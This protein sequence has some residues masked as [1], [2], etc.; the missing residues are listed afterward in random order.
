MS[1][2]TNT[3][4]P[5]APKGGHIHV[6][7]VPVNPMRPWGDAVDAIGSYA[8]GEESIHQIG[9]KYPPQP[10]EL[11]E[12]E[13]ILV[14]FGK[15]IPTGQVALDWAQSNALHQTNPRGSF[16]VGEHR[17]QFPAELGLD[18]MTVVS[19]EHFMADDE[20]HVCCVWWLGS[21]RN[22]LAVKFDDGWN[23][24]AWFAFEQPV[25]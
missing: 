21:E 4:A 11:K 13:I 6:L 5:V 7:C 24:N 18:H 10:G 19:T 22:A 9:D 25:I 8:L 2:Q 16:A 17:Q 12:R 20:R 1:V 23:A 15:N 3:V 14:N